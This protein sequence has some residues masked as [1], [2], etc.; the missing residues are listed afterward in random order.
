MN[1]SIIPPVK[2]R[3]DYVEFDRQLVYEKE[4]S[5]F[6]LLKISRLDHAGRIG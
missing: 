3:F 1:P 6:F 4:S 5:E 2:G